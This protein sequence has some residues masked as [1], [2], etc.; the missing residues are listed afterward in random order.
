MITLEDLDRARLARESIRESTE[1]LNR[2]RSSS[3]L[4]SP[5]LDGMPHSSGPS[6][7]TGHMA[8]IIVDLEE[9]IKRRETEFESA[10]A[11]CEPFVSSI[12]NDITRICFRYRFQYAMTYKEIAS[13]MG[14]NYSENSVKS[15]IY[16]EIRNQKRE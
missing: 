16:R 12:E 9:T 15:R 3:G 10:W 6:D 8:V 2:I 7:H 1:M 4:K 11:V 13:V 14:I 5:E